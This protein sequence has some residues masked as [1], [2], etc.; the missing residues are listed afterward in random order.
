VNP[1]FN[2]R[3]PR[4]EISID[5]EDWMRKLCELGV[6]NIT[7]AKWAMPFADEVQPGRFSAGN[8]DLVAWLPQ[9]LHET[10]MLESLTENLTYSADRIRELGLASPEG[11]RWRSMVPRAAELSHNPAGFAEA[12]YGGR[13]GNT[14]PGDGYR[15][16]GRALPMLTGRAAY[17]RIGDLMGQ[18]LEGMPEL[19]EQPHYAIEVGIFWWEG[20][21]SDDMLG[22]QVKLRRRVNGGTFGLAHC[23]QLADLTCKVFA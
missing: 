12:V 3:S 4:F 10:G 8:A 5:A 21:V 19:L 16:R 6:R 23:Q 13:M 7:A 11:S 15:F 2:S 1:T 14:M 9:I 18:D 22:D 17:R 20:T